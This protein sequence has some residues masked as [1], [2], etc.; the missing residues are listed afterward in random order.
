MADK[1]WS[2]SIKGAFIFC[3]HVCL[4][5]VHFFGGGGRRLCIQN[6]QSALKYYQ[7]KRNFGGD[8]MKGRHD[9]TRDQVE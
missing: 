9:D 8:R 7:M 2:V 6:L 3:R 1:M 5:G 4:V